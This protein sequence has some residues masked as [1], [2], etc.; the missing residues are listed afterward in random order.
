MFTKYLENYHI[1]EKWVSRGRTITETDLVLFASFSGDWF[2]LHTNKEYAEKTPYKQRIAHGLLVLS[3]ASGLFQFEPGVVVAFYGMEN[4]RFMNPTFIGDTIHVEV[5]ITD[6]EEK[7]KRR[8]V[9]TTLQKIK[10]HSGEIVV[11]SVM[12]LMVNRTPEC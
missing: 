7:D 2:V 3:A 1:G 9:I 12:K 11:V 4:V 10:K 6:I 5:D 8:G